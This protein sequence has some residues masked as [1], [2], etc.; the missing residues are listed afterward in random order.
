MCKCKKGVSYTHKQT[1]TSCMRK[2]SCESHSVQR[3]KL[4]APLFDHVSPIHYK[5]LDSHYPLPFQGKI[6]SLLFMIK[7]SRIIALICPGI[8]NL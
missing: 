4:Y 8:L 6:Q 1:N 3:V 2:Y 7:K 5:L